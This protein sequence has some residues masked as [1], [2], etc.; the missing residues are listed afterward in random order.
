MRLKN[1]A[2]HFMRKR[3]H[4][5]KLTF[6]GCCVGLSVG[7]EVG[8]DVCL[9]DGSYI[10]GYWQYS[11]EAH[12]NVWEQYNVTSCYLFAE[13]TSVTCLVGLFVGDEVGNGVG[14]ADGS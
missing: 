11:M 5:S 14:L 9:V 2:K 7:D 10:T 13:L 6:V 4:T 3:V 8:F 1:F 12:M